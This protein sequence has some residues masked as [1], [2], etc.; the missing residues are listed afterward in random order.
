MNKEHLESFLVSSSILTVTPKLYL[1]KFSQLSGPIY[2][3]LG[4]HESPP[5]VFRGTFWHANRQD[6]ITPANFLGGIVSIYEAKSH[7]ST[8]LS[9]THV[10]SRCGVVLYSWK[11]DLVRHSAR[12]SICRQ[13]NCLRN[14]MR[15][16]VTWP[17]SRELQQADKP[18]DNSADHLWYH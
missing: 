14:A 5:V 18:A 6:K 1:P 15:S 12:L 13:S 4:F 17:L 7:I 2:I 9:H 3:F 16:G 10:C 8:F 11:S